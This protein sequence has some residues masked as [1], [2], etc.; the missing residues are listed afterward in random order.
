MAA[1]NV[2]E[3]N[4][5]IFVG[6]NRVGNNAFFVN[7][8]IAK[9]INFDL[10][11]KEALEIYTDWRIRESRNQSGTLSYLFGKERF[12]AIS[13]CKVLNLETNSILS[14]SDL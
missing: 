4:G 5:L 3:R 6:S 7:S 14:V 2:M 10:P 11:K 12:S 8:L 1:I 13:E 9:N